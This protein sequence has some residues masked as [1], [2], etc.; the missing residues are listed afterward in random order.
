MTSVKSLIFLMHL[1][2]RKVKYKRKSL[3]QSAPFSNRDHTYSHVNVRLR[4]YVEVEKSSL[5]I[6]EG[7]VFA[8]NRMET[9]V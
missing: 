7:L 3:K 9:T 4:I 5:Y 8:S 2:K 6:Q 1:C